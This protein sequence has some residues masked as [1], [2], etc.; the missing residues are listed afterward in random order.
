MPGMDDAKPQSAFEVKEPRIKEDIPSPKAEGDLRE[1]FDLPLTSGRDPE[2]GMASDRGAADAT[3]LFSDEGP[4][5]RRITAA[6]ARAKARRCVH[7]G[8]VVPRGMS[9]CTTCGTD[10]ETG[11]RVGLDDDLAPPPRPPPEGPPFHVSIIGGLCIAA[12]LILLSFSVRESVLTQSVVEQCAWLGLAA[13]AIFCI[14]ASVQLIRG[15]SAKM[16]IVALTLAVFVDVGALIALPII[17]ANFEERETII[18]HAQPEQPTDVSMKI[19]PVEDRI[20]TNR[21]TFGVILIVIYALLSVYLISRPVQ[22]YIHSQVD[23]HS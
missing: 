14:T 10:Q 12:A 16:L 22:R 21:I 19:K 6:Q 3:T 23:R 15:K 18:T 11:L 13:V 8:G 9:I 2:H 20:D 1:A 5:E 7:C 4:S 17:R